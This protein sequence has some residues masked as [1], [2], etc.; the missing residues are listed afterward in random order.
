MKNRVDEPIRI[1]HRAV[2]RPVPRESEPWNQIK[3]VKGRGISE[4]EFPRPMA[5]RLVTRR[6]QLRLRAV[7]GFV[8]RF[9]RYTVSPWL[10]Q[11]KRVL[12]RDCQ[13]G[14]R[15]VPV[16]IE[17]TSSN[18]TRPVGVTPRVTTP[19][20][21]PR[22]Q[23]HR[24]DDERTQTSRAA[25]AVH[26]REARPRRRRASVRRKGQRVPA[27]PDQAV[28]QVPPAPRDRGRAPRV[29]G[30]VHGPRDEPHVQAVLQGASRREAMRER[31]RVPAPRARLPELFPPEM[32]ITP[33]APAR[34]GVSHSPPQPRA[35]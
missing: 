2:K 11:S 15:P 9:D 35:T 19:R 28:P 26:R 24:R 21:P 1:I 3:R 7:T 6:I 10:R 23:S 18:E 22:P 8:S 17:E 27:R 30:G 13:Q 25:R 12:C 29:L 20:A 14:C 32:A 34:S 33:S 4:T 31:A 16:V 5:S